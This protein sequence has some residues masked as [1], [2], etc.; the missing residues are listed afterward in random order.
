MRPDPDIAKAQQ[1]L[2]QHLRRELDNERVLRAM[3][4]VPRHLFVPA[5]HRH[6][7]YDDIPLPIG[8]GQTISQPF[9]VALMTSAL[10][11]KDDD[12]VLELGTGSGYQTAILSCLVPQG[13][14]LSVEKSPRLAQGARMLLQALRYDNVEVRVVDRRLGAP[15]EAPFDAILVTAGAPHLPESL[16]EQLAPGGRMV[17]PV[18]TR[19][20]QDLLKVRKTDDGQSIE[21]LGPCRFVPLIGED[22]W[23]ESSH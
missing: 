8:E 2:F 21:N 22:A 23:E 20:E 6:L 11:L 7:A 14:V 12:R 16:S 5:A 18:G 4:Q 10:E 9:I 1:R 13:H 15:D 19:H 17:I 3:E